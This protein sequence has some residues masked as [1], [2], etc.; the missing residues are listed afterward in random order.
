M[1]ASITVGSFDLVWIDEY[2]DM[3]MMMMMFNK[4]SHSCYLLLNDKMTDELQRI[5]KEVV[6]D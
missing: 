5:E 4:F 3:M 6:M 1:T 2:K